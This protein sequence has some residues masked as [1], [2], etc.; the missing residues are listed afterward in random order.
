VY[1]ADDD[2]E[3]SNAREDSTSLTPPSLKHANPRL[4]PGE[5]YYPHANTKVIAK[6][7]DTLLKHYPERLHRAI[8]VPGKGGPVQIMWNK[9]IPSSRTR[10]KVTHLHRVEE[11][12][13]F[14]SA[15]EMVTLVGG[16]AVVHPNAF[17]S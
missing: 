17:E 16:N 14:I 9:Y 7:I 11:L 3:D 10:A 6:L 2:D 4:L 8:I 12:T 1:K 13:T 5:D 15:N